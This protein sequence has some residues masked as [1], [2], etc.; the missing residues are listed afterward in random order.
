[1]GIYFKYIAR[2]KGQFGTFKKEVKSELKVKLGWWSEMK[3]ARV[4]IYIKILRICINKNKTEELESSH[5][6]ALDSKC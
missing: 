3:I 2:D 5:T 4:Q 6:T 1:M